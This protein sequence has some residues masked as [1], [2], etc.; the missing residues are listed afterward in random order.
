MFLFAA[1]S[2]DSAVIEEAERIEVLCGPQDT[3]YGSGSMFIRDPL[4]TIDGTRFIQRM[5]PQL[6]PPLRPEQRRPAHADVRPVNVT[7]LSILL[8]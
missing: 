5:L 2:A 6:P 8:F 3:L 1:A 7:G 4:V